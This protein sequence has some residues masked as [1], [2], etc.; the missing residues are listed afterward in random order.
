VRLI[1]DVRGIYQTGDMEAF[2][3]TVERVADF[4]VVGH[5]NKYGI[6]EIRLGPGL[7][8]ELSQSEIG[9]SE[10]RTIITVGEP[11]K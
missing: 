3:V 9:I 1:D 11:W 8:E 6:V 7:F 4:S 10:S 5:Y 2:K